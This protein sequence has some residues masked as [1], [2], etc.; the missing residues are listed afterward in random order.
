M[1]RI[2]DQKSGNK[3]AKD[4]VMVRKYGGMD[5]DTEEEGYFKM[6]S[7]VTW[8]LRRRQNFLLN[9]GGK[10]LKGGI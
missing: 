1:V 4:G 9:A 10:A 7:E 5:V 8:T 2:W 6:R 3:N